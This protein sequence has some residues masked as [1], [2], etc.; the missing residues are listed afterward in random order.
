MQSVYGGKVSVAEASLRWM[1]L[2]SHLGANDAVVLGASNM[3]NFEEN[4][5]A[6]ECREELESRVLVAFDKAWIAC[7]SCDMS[8]LYFR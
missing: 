7:S 4:L 1:A 6:L 5:C 8:P 2:H 3:K